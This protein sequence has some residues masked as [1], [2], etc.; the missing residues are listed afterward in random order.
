M[1]FFLSWVAPVPDE[2]DELV[3]DHLRILPRH[4]LHS[5]RVRLRLTVRLRL[6]A[7]HLL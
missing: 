7:R 1:V 5:L 2:R 6:L 4:L 3:E